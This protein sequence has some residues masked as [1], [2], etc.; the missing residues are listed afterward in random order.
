MK[1]LCKLFVVFF[2]AHFI[3]CSNDT[4]DEMSVVTEDFNNNGTVANMFKVS[5][6]EAK[7]TLI[8]FLGQFESGSS[9]GVRSTSQRTI[10]DI[11]AFNVNTTTRSS[12]DYDYEI[13]DDVETLFYLI[14]FD[15][16][17]GFG[18]VSGDKRT[19][20]VLAIIDEGSLSLD[21]L[22]RVE[23]TG[24]LMFLDQAVAMQMEEMLMYDDQGGGGGGS[25]G[26]YSPNSTPTILLDV[27]IR[28]KTKWG[29]REPYNKFSPN[30]LAGC[31]MVAGAQALS[32]FQTVG[33]VQWQH[34]NSYG[35]SVLNW[36]KIIAD[37]EDT[38]RG[39]GMLSNSAPEHNQSGLQVSHLMR[40]LGVAVNA[41]Y[42]QATSKKNASTGADTG[43]MVKHL[44][45][46][47]GLSGSTVI[48][49]YGANEVRNALSQNPNSL[50]IVE[51]W[52]NRT[53]KFLGLIY[54]YKD[55][56]AWIIDGARRVQYSSSN[57]KDYVHCNWEWNSSCDG[58]FI[59]G[60]FNTQVPPEFTNPIDGGGT[61][62]YNFRYQTHYA[63]LKR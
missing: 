55:G 51:S 50:V 20:P 43:D 41:N 48:Y 9:D 45:N 6:D 42:N 18:I 5:E 49:N 57:I 13:P 30:G 29:Q 10:K 52:A 22:S 35:S 27:P 61:D 12:S 4:I 39:Y 24:F 1:N 62:N 11:Q 28:L 31:V 16:D 17:Q 60:S 59:S 56:H 7:E 21:T 63:V 38:R 14:N 15:D 54:Q 33:S 23:N 32:Y 58:Y 44:K 37:S 40:Y 53:N 2:I 26:G 25:S 3:A 8:S 36:S 34:N 19:T 47:C 46:W